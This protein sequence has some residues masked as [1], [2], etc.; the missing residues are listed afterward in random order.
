MILFVVSV[1]ALAHLISFKNDQMI[2]GVSFNSTYA[3]YLGL[4][5]KQVLQTI[6]GEWGFKNLRISAPWIEV[7]N[8][9]GIFDFSDID[10]Q[11]DTIN[12][13]GGK[14]VL[15]IGQKTP[16]WPECH[17]PDWA[18]TLTDEQFFE[19]LQNYVKAVVERYRDNPAVEIWQVENEPFLPFGGPQCR[20]FKVEWLKEEIK[21]VKSLD[22]KHQILV[23]D[24][25]ELSTWS[26]TAQAGDLFGSTMYRV[27]WNKYL[28]YWNY[29]WLPPAFYRAKLWLNGRDPKTS[30]I[31]ELQAEPW[32]PDNTVSST[33]IGEQFM[34]M[35]LDRLQNHLN[36]AVKVGLP[37]TYLWGAEWWYWLKIKG[38]SEISDF[39]LKLKKN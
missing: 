34:S 32:I 9:K 12:K 19:K 16:R 6:V 8:T 29:D 14:V 39:I 33:K 5:S 26:R 23:S 11:L 31:M 18:L 17:T 30:F 22:P 1:T 21:L 35:N 10:W 7:E 4:D 24:S 15:S 3:N 25:G 27:V 37:R 13:S 36:F 38:Y 28:G 20:P 2:W